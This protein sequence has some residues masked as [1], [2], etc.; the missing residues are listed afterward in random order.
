MRILMSMFGWQDSGG[1]TIM[2]RQT[3]LD[4]QARGHEVMVIYAAVPQLPGEPAY[5]VR[6]HS[7]AGVRLIGIHNR[8]AVF[9]DA[10]APRREAHDPEIRRIFEDYLEA[11]Q[12]DVVHYHN[13]LGLSLA[14]ADPVWERGLPNFYTPYNFWLLCPTLYLNLPDL[15]LCRGVNASG[16]NCLQCTRAPLPGAEYVWRRDQ[17]RR[18][19]S[20]RIGACLA[21]SICVRDLLLENGYSSERVELFQLA[22]GRAAKIWQAVGAQRA[23]G[24]AQRIQIGFT[25]QVVPIKGVHILVQAAQHLQGDFEVVIHGGGPDT[26]MAYLKQLDTRG[27]V[28]FAGYFDDADHADLLAQ[29]HLAVVPSV[30]FDH[31]PLVISE[32]LA[33]RIPVIGADIGGIPDYIPEGCGQLYPAEQPEALAAVLQALIDQPEQIEA[34]QARISE[35][36]SF[37]DYVAALETRYAQALAAPDP[38]RL[39]QRVNYV[40]Q[41]RSARY[42]KAHSLQ[43]IDVQH[44][45]S[46]V[47][48]PY[49]LDLLS[50]ADL[51]AIPAAHLQA[52]AWIVFA[53]PAL[54]PLLAEAAPD[55]PCQ[56]ILPLRATLPDVHLPWP[57]EQSYSLLLLLTPAD[58]WQPVLAAYW[59]QTPADTACVLVPWQQSLEA[60]QETLLDWL[61][62]TGRDPEQ[63]PELVLVEAENEDQL[64]SLLQQAA[65][66]A[67]PPSLCADEALLPVLMLAACL[68]TATELPGGWQCQLTTQLLPDVL[69][70]MQQALPGWLACQTEQDAYTHQQTQAALWM[71]LLEALS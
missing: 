53:D 52:A 48:V 33:A 38:E 15:S 7:E 11:F 23:P 10:H 70:S 66:S 71:D 35:P 55:V 60:A 45:E 57:T 13:F 12:P 36:P 61:D 8:P 4:L 49:G 29:M 2:P 64:K 40:L 68:L 44:P 18:L 22:N 26:Y 28:R 69:Q 46:P 24:V 14:I 51:A 19:Y 56:Q 1:G 3:A 63:G 25:G 6:E 32:F 54:A 43:P 17:L 9:L 16:S 20:E 42:Y 47:P 41:H 58:D 30:C 39:R 34:M 50:E 27:V 67:V 37:A 59:D 21:T 5:T 62:A 65:L 31:S